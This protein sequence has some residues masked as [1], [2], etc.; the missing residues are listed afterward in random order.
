M[1]RV[2]RNRLLVAAFVIVVIL[3]SPRLPDLATWLAAAVVFPFIGV[4]LWV[5]LPFQRARTLLSKAQYD[6]AAMQIAAFERAMLESPWKSKV[7]SLAVGLYT[8]NPVAASRNTLAAIRLEQGRLKDAARSLTTSL[9]LDPGYAVPWANRAVL[10]AMEGDR[11]RAEEALAKAKSLGFAPRM[12]S[13]VI[14]DKLAAA[15]V[16]TSP[17]T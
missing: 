10:A 12:L 7:A 14:E 1:T 3:I 6:D 4:A 17:T 5:T 11:A 2:L 9:E 15:A 8:S 13:K 16:A